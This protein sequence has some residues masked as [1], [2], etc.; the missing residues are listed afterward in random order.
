MVKGETEQVPRCSRRSP[1][2]YAVDW[3][4]GGSACGTFDDRWETYEHARKWADRW[5]REGNCDDHGLSDADV[6]KV[7]GQ[8]CY[9]A[10]HRGG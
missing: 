2:H 1:V 3:D 5:A 6:A 4:D 9:T 7:N 8:G 10:R